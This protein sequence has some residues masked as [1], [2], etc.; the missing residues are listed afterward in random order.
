MDSF[1]SAEQSTSKERKLRLFILASIL[2]FLTWG[3][4]MNHVQPEAYDPLWVRTLAAVT[5]FLALVTSY[6]V[7]NPLGF[8]NGLLLVSAYVLTSHSYF[9]MIENNFVGFTGAIMILGIVLQ[10]LPTRMMTYL[11]VGF[12][13][14]FVFVSSF[15][16]LGNSHLQTLFILATLGI[17][18]PGLLFKHY[19]LLIVEQLRI[20]ETEKRMI[21]HS[22]SD[23]LTLQNYERKI[24]SA[25]PAALKILG[26]SK[27]TLFQGKGPLKDFL[28]FDESGQNLDPVNFPSNVA[29]RTSAPIR[30]FLMGV[31]NTTTKEKKWLNVSSVP[32]F[33]NNEKLPK[34][35]LTSFQDVTDL[36]K[37]QNQL[38]DSQMQMA[39]ASKLT[40][41]GEMASGIAHEVNNPL[42]IIQGKAFQISTIL[43]DNP[44][45]PL[46]QEHLNKIEETVFRIQKIVRGLRS[47][48]RQADG[49]PF[50]K[51][52]F[53]MIL[54]DTMD[55]CNEKLA[56][57]NIVVT[58][59]LQA[60]VNLD[61]RPGQISQI[62]MNLLQNAADAVST[63]VQK[64]IDI[65]AF[66][67]DSKFYLKVYDSGHGVPPAIQEKIMQPFFTTKDVG[68]GTGLGLS[69]SM[70][71]ARQHKGNLYLDRSESKTCFVLELPIEQNKN[72]DDF[73]VA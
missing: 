73:Q 39:Q 7:K 11:Y 25:N 55:L 36:R 72:I 21:L 66:Q 51:A 56:K 52:N 17:L 31:E 57:A 50:E 54:A 43:K 46:I 34:A 49:D 18:I 45:L 48:A 16:S 4:V 70:G 6:Y 40:S 12:N 1:S 62:L 41:L 15:F 35:T 37:A 9:L 60:D 59:D 26:V 27:E 20:S 32:L 63:S 61:C 8:L 53:K 28:F 65:K 71:I 47:F 14:I 58:V 42:A 10:A 64:R 22:M 38:I 23:G 69:I 2:V 19:H 67:A 24:L 13:L 5:A 33:Q 3:M 30:N 44:D 68:R 29:F